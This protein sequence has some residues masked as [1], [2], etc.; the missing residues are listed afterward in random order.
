LRLDLLVAS[1]DIVA[2]SGSLRDRASHLVAVHPLRA[3]VALQLAAAI[4]SSDT[5]PH[6]DGFVTLDDRLSRA[7]RAE[8]FTVLPG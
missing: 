6:G 7:A 8:G 3:A 2:P 5:T 4:V 1:V